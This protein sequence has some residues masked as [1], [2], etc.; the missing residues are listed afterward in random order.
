[1]PFIILLDFPTKTASI[2][3]S[4]SGSTSAALSSPMLVFSFRGRTLHD[5]DRTYRKNTKNILIMRI[6]VLANSKSLC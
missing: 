3:G 6:F 5:P 1:M 2:D 4:D